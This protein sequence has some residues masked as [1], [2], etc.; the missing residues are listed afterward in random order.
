M[1]PTHAHHVYKYVHMYIDV[2][3]VRIVCFYYFIH[4]WYQ[5]QQQQKTKLIDIEKRVEGGWR[6]SEMGE[7]DQL[8]GDGW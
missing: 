4:M 7:R 2:L 1:Q 6:L 3:F 8:Y 5:K